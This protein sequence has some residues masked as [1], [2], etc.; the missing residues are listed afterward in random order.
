MQEQ[1]MSN[2]ASSIL[3]H[4]YQK[5]NREFP[6]H[7]IHNDSEAERATAILERLFRNSFDDPGEEE[8]VMA[9][10]TLLDDYDRERH[11]VKMNVSGLDM[12]KEMMEQH[13]LKQ[14]ELCEILGVGASA[15]SMILKGDRPITADHARALGKRFSIDPGVFIAV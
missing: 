8:Y 1:A 2:T 14:S 10:A 5:L 7:V 6:L 13:Q 15:I 11:P 3:T 4:R 9:L 12:L